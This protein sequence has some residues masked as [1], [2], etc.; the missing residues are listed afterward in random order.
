MDEVQV[1]RRVK[2]I[3]LADAQ[4][5]FRA[6]LARVLSMQGG[7]SVQAQ[8]GDA[9]AAVEMV[10]SSHSAM[11]IV[12]ESLLAEPARMLAAVAAADARLIVIE[13]DGALPGETM[14][15]VDAVIPRSVSSEGLL[16]CVERVA[17]GEQAVTVNQPV[18]HDVLGRDLFSLKELEILGYL[19]Q[20]HK[21]RVIAQAMR[22]TEQVIK[23]NLRTISDKTGSADRLE[24]ALFTLHH[25]LLNEVPED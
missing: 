6:G 5:L 16:N 3:L 12:A 23:N 1:P 17:A 2:R 21:N 25:G 18:A 14:R 19:V 7:W 22:T 9:E 15:R 10:L 8:T 24:L 4:P 11:L 13:E 20:G